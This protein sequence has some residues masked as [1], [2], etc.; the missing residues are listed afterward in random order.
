MQKAKPSLRQVIRHEFK[1]QMGVSIEKYVC[2][3][4]QNMSSKRKTDGGR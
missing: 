1:K 4:F 2:E 3:I